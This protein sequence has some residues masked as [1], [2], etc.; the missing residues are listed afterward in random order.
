MTGS[1]G[2]FDSGIGGLTV[3]K[4]LRAVLP[5]ESLIYLGDTARVPYGT[6]S[7]E[8]VVKYSLEC[9]KFL[10]QRDIKALVVAC[11]TS[12]AYSLPALNKELGVEVIGVIQ[13]GARMAL[14]RSKTGHIGV[15]GTPAT[16]ASN[17]YARAIKEIEPKARV[18]SQACPL[19][20]PLVEEGWLDNEVAF[21][22]AKIYLES[23]KN[24]KIDTLIL[25]CTHY[26]LL[27]PV[28]GKVLG[29]EVSL[30]DSAC[31][32]ADS[33]KDELGRQNLLAGSSHK[34]K[35]QIYVTDMAA[36]FETVAH[37]FLGGDVPSVK[38]VEL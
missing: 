36:R 11:N 29:A 32:V 26:P 1:I 16:I 22:T 21:G 20:V 28:I 24:E 27:K 9:A 35:Y 37:R 7:A 13:P 12:S 10:V 4:A 3:F 5:N 31:A 23:F 38:R 19:F 30:I 25:G 2:I 18:I 34:G 15:I 6:K 14:L 33:V 17:A 8:T